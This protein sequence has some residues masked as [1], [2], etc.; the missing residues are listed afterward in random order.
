MKIPLIKP[1]ITQD[2]KDKVCEVLDSGYLT[3]GSVTKQFEEE[4]AKFLECKYCLAVTSA[5][6]GLEVALRALGIGEG[7]EVIVPDY[8]YPA[9]ASVMP[10]VGATAVVV[11]VD[12]N[13]MLID[14]DRLEEAITPKTKAIMPVSLFGHPL[15]YARLNQIKEKYNLKIIEDAAC[16]IGAEFN[17]VKVGNQADI[18]IFSL[19]PRKFITT[20]EGG[21]IAT[22]NTEWADWMNSYKHFGMNMSNTNREGIQ[23]EIIGTNYKLTNIQAA[24]GL[25]QLKHIHVL[26][27]KRIDLANNYTKLLAGVEGITMPKLFGSGKCSENCLCENP[28]CVHSYQTY[29]IFVNDRDRIMTEMRA[30]DIEVQI[31]TYSLH[32]HNAFKINKNVRLFGSF[33]NSTYCYKHALA[34]PL[35]H[36]LSFAQ[37]EY[38]VSEV[39]KCL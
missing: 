13:S 6:T 15:D 7:D 26:L 18:T 3:E 23:F 10:I 33:N 12:I 28:K 36:E 32:M 34:L 24:I 21:V 29:S 1:Y 35:Y 25:G 39:K 11:D 27:Q 5:T 8:T 38:V 2:I 16:S 37:Q 9:T 22:N 30:K 20:G 4:L 17:G 31:G 14:Y 19:H